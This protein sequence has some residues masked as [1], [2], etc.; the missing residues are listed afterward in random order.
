LIGLGDETTVEKFTLDG[1][2][3]LSLPLEF[4]RSTDEMVLVV[5]GTARFTRQPAA[6]RFTIKP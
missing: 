6:Y 5:S 1:D 2:N 3:R 4:D